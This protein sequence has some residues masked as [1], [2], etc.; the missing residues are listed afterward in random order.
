MATLLIFVFPLCFRLQL[1]TEEAVVRNEFENFVQAYKIHA[2]S[3]QTSENR[4]L[5]GV[6]SELRLFPGPVP[7]LS[8]SR[9]TLRWANF[10]RNLGYLFL[11]TDIYFHSSDVVFYWVLFRLLPGTLLKCQ[12]YKLVSSQNSAFDVAAIRFHNEG[13]KPHWFWGVL[14]QKIIPA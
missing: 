13:T 8:N 10:K 11:N 2:L 12:C 1:G 7:S 14:Y 4:W 5:Q 9:A 3:L 6:W